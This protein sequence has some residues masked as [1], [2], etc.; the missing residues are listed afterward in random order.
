[1][2]HHHSR[3]WALLLAAAAL[4]LSLS[5]V[6][7]P[8]ANI[9]IYGP[10]MSAP[11]GFRPQ[12]E[13]TLAQTAGH[14]VTVAN[15]AAW[16]GLTAAQFAAFDAIVFGDPTCGFVG[17]LAAAE[18]NR[19][20]WSSVV[21]GPIYV[22]GTDPQWHQ[23][24]AAPQG[25]EALQM[26]TNGINFAASGPGTGLYVSLSCYYAGA[27]DNTPVN[28]LDQLGAFLVGGQGGCTSAATI[29]DPTHPAM[30]GLT[31]AGLSNWGC[32]PHEFLLGFPGGLNVLA[33]AIRPTDGGSYP[34]I[35]ASPA[36]LIVVIDIKPGSDPNGINPGAK[37]VIPVAIL[38]TSTAD[39]DPLDFD[40]WDVDPA[41]LAFGA[42]GAGIVHGQGHAE[43]VD[44]DGDIDM[45]VHFKTKET[46]ILCGDTQ[47]T[48]TG[49]T[50]GGQQ[51]MGT[52]SVKTAGCEASVG[53]SSAQL[54]PSDEV[55]RR[56]VRKTKRAVKRHL[57]R[58]QQRVL[59]RGI[60][61]R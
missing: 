37:G 52:D 26:I 25:P 23:L 21:N 12:N 29:T 22:Q 61:Q 48:L 34:F 8:A 44:G 45:V 15:A 14:T 42:G 43:D 7:A 32:S 54:G 3:R 59:R 40:A 41:S 6:P 20:V 5:A 9:L 51:I 36:V 46:G 57:K 50:F 55:M 16:A 1:M 19:A 27:P 17:L 53:V 11:T 56:A 38:T 10:S 58:G 47:A 28:L 18:A 13:Q 49:Q 60:N 2:K 39:G 35:I 33:T 31:N 24:A 4:G 30:A